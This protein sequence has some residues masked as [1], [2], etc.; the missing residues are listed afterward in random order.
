MNF[1]SASVLVGCF[2]PEIFHN[3]KAASAACDD[4]K[5]YDKILSTSQ[6]KS[7]VRLARTTTSTPTSGVDVVDSGRPSCRCVKVALFVYCDELL[8]F[9]AELLNDITSTM[10]SS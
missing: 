10:T 7:R 6:H 4:R 3:D 1:L 8:V 2:T 5:F 9:H